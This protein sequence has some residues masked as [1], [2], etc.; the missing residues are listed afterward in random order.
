MAGGSK[1]GGVA[2]AGRGGAE[3]NNKEVGG[4]E[5]RSGRGGG[6]ADGRGG[7]TDQC[8]DKW[9]WTR[10]AVADICS[11][12]EGLASLLPML[13]FLPSHNTSSLS[14]RP[15]VSSSASHH[16]S[17]KTSLLISTST[18][19]MLTTST[20][21]FRKS[22][23]PT[24]SVVT[25]TTTLILAESSAL[26]TSNFHVTPTSS[27]SNGPLSSTEFWK[28]K[29]SVAGTFTV[30]GLLIL[31]LIG[32]AAY[33]LARRR[34]RDRHLK[35]EEF[36][37]KRSS[38]RGGPS[39]GPSMTQI[40]IPAAP[41]AYVSRD[42]HFGPSYM[43]HRGQ[44]ADGLQPFSNNYYDLDGERSAHP[45][46]SVGASYGHEGDN[47]PHTSPISHSTSPVPTSYRQARGRDSAAYQPSV[48]SFYGGID[49]H[50]I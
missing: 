17:T 45:S 23:I 39:P 19:F 7:R 25:I 21:S 31:S 9:T 24:T 30:A 35:I 13:S 40:T 47:L 12:A 14:L 11:P 6:G 37:D 4:T 48:D 32:A 44:D 5:W 15:S 36:F 22:Q 33:I 27:T 49:G 50:A 10:S 46:Y 42:I 20:I 26:G 18:K 29:G 34:R 28:N 43:Y 3:D 1:V 8:R 16:A 41:R 38:T 2:Y